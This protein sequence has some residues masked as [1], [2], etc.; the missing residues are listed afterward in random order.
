MI[1]I[2]LPL[3]QS[4]ALLFCFLYKRRTV[5]RGD[6]GSKKEAQLMTHHLIDDYR[7]WWNWLTLLRTQPDRCSWERHPQPDPTSSHVRFFIDDVH[8]LTVYC[9]QGSIGSFYGAC[10][11][12]G[13]HPLHASRFVKQLL[14]EIDRIEATAQIYVLYLRWPQPERQPPVGTPHWST[15]DPGVVTI[16]EAQKIIPFPKK[17]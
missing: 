6:T 7:V 15:L 9:I 5:K 12:P 17:G 14:Q 2:R 11:L 4:G 1:P 3:G 16:L 8:Q 10:S 13:G